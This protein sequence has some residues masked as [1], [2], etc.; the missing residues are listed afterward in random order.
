MHSRTAISNSSC[1]IGNE[2]ISRLDILERLYAPLLIPP[3]V[4]AEWRALLP[5]WITVQA[6]VN[7]GLVQSLQNQIGPG[8]SEAIALALECQVSRILLDDLQARQIAQRL[9][10]PIVG[11]AGILLRAKQQ[12][13]I[14]LVRPLLDGLRNTG[15]YLSNTIYNQVLQQAGE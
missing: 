14:P 13:V 8:E 4:A 9:N 1:L 2:R 7:Q 6:V 5:S 12:G 3:A 11:A 10:L 15:F